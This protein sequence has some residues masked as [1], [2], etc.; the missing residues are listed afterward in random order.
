MSG[1]IGER[2]KS[3]RLVADFDNSTGEAQYVVHG[4]DDEAEALALLMAEAA[5]TVTIDGKVLGKR[6]FTLDHAGYR[7]WS[8][9]VAYSR[10]RRET[11]ES[12]YQFETGGGGGFRVTHSIATSQSV[13]AGG[14]TPINM[15]NAIGWNGSEITGCDI[16]SSAF[17]FSETHVFAESAVDGAYKLA[18]FNAT[19][20][21]NN[22]GFKGF[23]AGEVL[24]LGASGS[25]RQDGTWEITYRFAASPNATGLTIAGIAGVDKKGWEYVWIHYKD[26]TSETVPVKQPV[27]VNVEQVYDLHDFA[28]IGIGT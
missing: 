4:T 23:A 6:V 7:V 16:I 28:N 19:G 21:V 15:Y 25:A 24:F 9:T 18:L 3:V 20:K 13:K 11:G 22:A 17:T 26:V 27:Q 10:R 1:V 14:G 12:T 8:G 5:A 2:V